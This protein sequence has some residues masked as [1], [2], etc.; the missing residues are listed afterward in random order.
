[1]VEF[2]NFYVAYKKV[3]VLTNINLTIRDGEFFVLIGASGCGKTTRLKSI[4]KLLPLLESRY[5]AAFKETTGLDASLR[6]DALKADEVDVVDAFATDALLSKMGL[7]KLT[8]N[9]QFFPPYQA[10]NFVD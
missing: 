4:N 7:T 6:Y 8:D 5:S 3:P 9:L 2:Q 10:V 1:M